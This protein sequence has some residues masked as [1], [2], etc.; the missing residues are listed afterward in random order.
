LSTTLAY[1]NPSQKIIKE[2]ENE[3]STVNKREKE[4]YQLT[5]REERKSKKEDS[6]DSIDS[7]PGFSKPK[8][9]NSIL[10]QPLH[11]VSI[12]YKLTGRCLSKPK[13]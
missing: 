2:E 1:I 13:V 10:L 12:I 9:L 4:F 8:S 11:S 7:R 5:A 6:I 3:Q